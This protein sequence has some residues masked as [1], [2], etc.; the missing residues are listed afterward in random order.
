VSGPATRLG[1]LASALLAALTFLGCGGGASVSS[2]PPPP[3]PPSAALAVTT[4]SL[5]KAVT[6]T[7]YNTKL[8]ASGGNPPYTWSLGP[9]PGSNVIS[10]LPPGLTLAGDGTI[11]G[12]AT[13]GCYLVWLPQFVV[14]DS[15]SQTARIGLELDCVAPLTISS[16]LL[17]DGNV[18][19][20]YSFIPSVQG[21][22][23]PYQYA[24]TAGSLAPGMTIDKNQGLQ[25]TPT[26][27]GKYSFTLQASDSGTATLTA[28]QTFT[29]NINNNLVLPKTALPDAVQNVAYLEQIQPSGGTPPYHFALGQFSSLPPGLSLNAATGQISGTPT[30]SLQNTDFLL[31]TISDSAPTP[32]TISPLVTLNVQPPLSFQTT[33]LP[34]SARGLNY[35]G[36]ISI[37]GG[38]APYSVQVASGSLP[39]GLSVSP[40]TFSVSGVPTKDGTFQ[41]TLKVSD[42]Y[43]TPNLVTQNFQIRISDPLALSGPSMV[44]ILYN[45]SYSATFPATGG[46]PPYTWGISSVPPGFTFDASTGTLSGTPTGASYTSPNVTVHDS[47]SPPQTAIDFNFV[48]EVWGK[49]VLETTSLPAIAT[50]SSVWLQPLT[51]GGAAPFQWSVSSGSL[52][53]GLNLTPLEGNATIAI[54]GSPTTAGTYSFTLS[55]SDGNPGA[56]H[57]TTSQQLTLTVKDRGQMTRNDTIATATPLSNISLLASISPYSDPSSAG[58][59]VD[60]YSA[61]AA[62][63]TIVQVYVSPNNDFLQPPEPNSLQPVLEIV[64]S[65][66]TR[67]QTCGYYGLLPGQVNDLPCINLLPGNQYLSNNYYAFQVPGSGTSAVTFFIRVLDARGDARPDFIYTLS[68]FAVN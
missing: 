4:T 9:P 27:A 63:G 1:L 3:P 36:N 28:S 14:K 54:V 15:S 29:L 35:G 8:Q 7:S 44:Q 67:Y 42:S 31:M 20:P 41:F 24:L 16:N 45:Q 52:P 34:D 59:D 13:A 43:E 68:V 40:T 30:T 26:A 58:P 65:T 38:R 17:P 33:K 2:P 12:S 64:D 61:S 46:I 37:V 49:L 66:G 53:P 11:G 39:D 60:Y 56:L 19:L 48:L 5:P 51:S 23:P 55:I 47:S 57:Q 18:A 22:L 10:M 62:P 21:G 25:G 50:G 6:G 32:A